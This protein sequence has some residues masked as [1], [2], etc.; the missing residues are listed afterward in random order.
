VGILHLRKDDLVDKLCEILEGWGT[1]S[2][3]ECC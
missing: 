1:G 2:I 3:L